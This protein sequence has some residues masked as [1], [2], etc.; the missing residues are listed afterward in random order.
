ML[1][2]CPSCQTIYQVDPVVPIILG[3]TVHCGAC[4]TEFELHSHVIRR[5]TVRGGVLGAR[6]R[7]G[8]GLKVKPLPYSGPGG[9]RPAP[10]GELVPSEWRA[11]PAGEVPSQAVDFRWS[12]GAGQRPAVNQATRTDQPDVA[13]LADQ[14]ADQ[15]AA[16]EKAQPAADEKAQPAAGEEVPS[17]VGKSPPDQALAG[18]TPQPPVDGVVDSAT[19]GE[20]AADGLPSGAAQ[21]ERKLPALARVLLGNPALSSA[22]TRLPDAPTASRSAWSPRR[23]DTRP[24]ETAPPAV[25]AP[26]PPVAPASRAPVA[27][28]RMAALGGVVNRGRQATIERPEASL[29][30]PPQLPPDNPVRL[31]ED[32]A[33]LAE[34]TDEP[35]PELGV[36]EQ[37]KR[38]SL[39][40]S[41]R[42]GTARRSD[43]A[44]RLEPS[45]GLTEPWPATGSDNGSRAARAALADWAAPE[46][47]SVSLVAGQGKKAGWSRPRPWTAITDLRASWPILGALAL[48]VTLLMQLAYSQ[49]FNLAD[50]DRGRPYAEAVCAVA[51]CVL[52]LPR[53]EGRVRLLR[54]SLV[55]HPDEPLALLMSAQLVNDSREQAAYPL[56]RLRLYDGR[57][58]VGQ[59]ARVPSG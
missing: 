38:F 48:V 40:S 31:A 22:V 37:V 28:T 52:P 57:A 41:T 55:E 5:S 20:P 16:D 15:P 11:T 10:G 56:L 14:R 46:R 27:T 36:S 13:Q 26:L 8:D 24:A 23:A 45:V 42:P 17:D 3:Q 21:V 2:R 47:A 7:A 32:A 39:P 33:R 50:S 9:T 51:G 29:A 59:G 53:A 58:T 19:D 54:T 49:R 43:A 34:L 25:K 4:N 18:S 12:L 6:E 30:V 35:I 44:P 1:V